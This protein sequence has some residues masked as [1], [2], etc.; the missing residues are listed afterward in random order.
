MATNYKIKNKQNA[1][2]PIQLDDGTSLHLQPAEAKEVAENVYNSRDCK[3]KIRAGY[4]QDFGP[5]V[6]KS[7]KTGG[8]S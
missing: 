3:A 2:L 8:G 4:L 6:T 5:V 7:A 1:P